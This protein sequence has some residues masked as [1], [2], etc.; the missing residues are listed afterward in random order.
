MPVFDYTFTVEAPFEAVSRFHEDPNVLKVLTPSPVRVHRMDPLAE[1]SITRFT[2][3]MGPVPIHW[4][5]EHSDLS[6]HG[7][8]DTQVEGPMRRWVHTHRFRPVGASTTEVHEHIEYEYG[9]GW[10][11]RLLCLLAFNPPALRGLFTYRKFRTRRALRA[12]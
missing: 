9:T 6:E 5:A 2:V 7:F 8:T 1:G 12:G 3:W 4:T 11:D 10:R